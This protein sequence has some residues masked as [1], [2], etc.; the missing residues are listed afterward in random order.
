MCC[1]EVELVL[2]KSEEVNRIYFTMKLSLPQT[3]IPM[4]RPLGDGHTG[5]RIVE[6]INF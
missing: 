5:Y 2:K 1:R 6:I 4:W 3:E